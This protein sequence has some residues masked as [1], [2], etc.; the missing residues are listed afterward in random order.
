MLNYHA[1]SAQ[2]AQPAQSAQS[3]QSAQLIQHRR[4]HSPTIT[5]TIITTTTHNNRLT[6]FLF[7]FVLMGLGV[8][9]FTL[10]ARCKRFSRVRE[11]LLP[12]SKNA[13]F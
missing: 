2:P 13:A 9:G 3:A 7:R 4:R 10:P 8:C 6:E 1:Q 12:G 5:T 11:A